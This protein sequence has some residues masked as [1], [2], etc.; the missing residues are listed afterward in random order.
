MSN[1][2]RRLLARALPLVL[3]VAFSSSLGAVS[4]SA[5]VV[6]LDA[7]FD[8]GLPAGW[9]KKQLGSTGDNWT[10]GFGLVNGSGD[11][12]HEWWCNFGFQLRNN[13]LYTP[14]VNLTG[15]TSAAVSFDQW[16]E[17]FGGLVGFEQFN[18]VVVSTNNG[19]TF[20]QIWEQPELPEPEGFS[21]VALDLGPW[22]GLNNVRVGFQYG[23]VV[24]ND[25][26][27]D[28]VRITAPWQDLGQGL[29]GGGGVP[30]LAVTGS[31][32]DASPLSIQLTAAAPSSTV[33]LVA[34]FA[35]WN[36]PFYGGTLVPAFEAPL[37]LFL[38]LGTDGAGALG[39]NAAWPGG[40]PPGFQ[41]T[42]Q[43][44]IVDGG[45]AFGLAA[46]NAVRGTVP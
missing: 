45:A 38:T 15:V 28:N 5:Q 12:N 16:H 7:N 44:W 2:V 18:R 20:T 34:G 6:L 10:V 36:L 23:G 3:A 26:S 19:N 1:P 21:H 40:V 35:E 42:L 11:M 24:G 9:I 32:A 39:I 37:G 30:L 27:V 46:S 4:A 22:V 13:F 33:Y 8:T 31:L 25:W 29:A 17:I 14:P 43:S 41:L